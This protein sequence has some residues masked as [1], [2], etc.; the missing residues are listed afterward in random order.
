[1]LNLKL[2]KFP[3][4]MDFGGK[5]N[6]ALFAH[7]VKREEI[8]NVICVYENKGGGVEMFWN[9]LRNEQIVNRLEW[10]KLQVLSRKV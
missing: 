8:K 2:L 7:R 4:A 3:T 5:R 10:L 6:V 1:V 9:G